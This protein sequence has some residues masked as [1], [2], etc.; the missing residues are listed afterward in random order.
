[1]VAGLGLVIFRARGGY[2]GLFGLR[3]IGIY[4]RYIRIME[5]DD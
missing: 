1:M 5:W 2:I 3:R 4:I